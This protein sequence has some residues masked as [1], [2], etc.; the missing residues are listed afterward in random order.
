[1]LLNIPTLELVTLGSEK[2]RDCP[3]SRGQKQWSWDG[4]QVHPFNQ[5]FPSVHYELDGG[6]DEMQVNETHSL[7]LRNLVEERGQSLYKM[8]VLRWG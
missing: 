1:M 2:E 6:P 8:M 7:A 5:C 3:W 4:T